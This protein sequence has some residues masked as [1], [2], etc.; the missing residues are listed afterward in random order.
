MRHG[1]S[2]AG[3]LVILAAVILRPAVAG[4]QGEPQVPREGGAP[5]PVAGVSLSGGQSILM[6]GI[7]SGPA[8]AGV[9][10]LSLGDA[11]ARGLK[12][13]LGIILG[14]AVAALRLRHPVA[15]GQRRSCRTPVLRISQAREEINLEEFGFPRRRRASRRSSGPFNVAA[16]HLTVSQSVFDYVGD[17]GRPRR[18]ARPRRR[19]G[20]PSTTPATWSPS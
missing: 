7:P 8:T 4:A 16:L 9:L 20:T 11:I 17:P 2:V 5:L 1:P 19:P 18:A 10:P 12:Q 14:R 15:G 6:G 3:L 13:N